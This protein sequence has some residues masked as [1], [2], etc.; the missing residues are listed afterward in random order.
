MKNKII[1][2]KFFDA[3]SP[4]SIQIADSTH[5]IPEIKII[6][7]EI[8][9]ESGISGQGY[10]LSFHYSPQA[11]IGTLKDLKNFVLNEYNVDETKKFLQDYKAETEY[12]GNLGLLKWAG[13][14][15]NVAMWDAYAKGINKSVWELLNGKYKP[16]PV[17]GSGGWLSY[18]LDELIEEVKS[19]VAR[20]FKAVKIKVGCKEI[21]KDIERLKK[22]REVVGDVVKIMIDANQGMTAD[23]AIKL[24]DGVNDLNIVWFE[25]PVENKNYE[26]YKKIKES[27][28][29]SLAMGEREYD[30]VALKELIKRKSIDMW[31]PDII[32]IGGVETWIESSRYANSFGIPVLPHYYKDYDVPLLCTIDNF[33]AAEFF[34]WIDGLIDNPLEIKYG[35]AY[36]RKAPGW[37][38][39]FT[40]NRLS[41]LNI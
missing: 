21:E 3:I 22:V 31:Q 7:T 18:T 1:D 34:D 15:L 9:T 40:R 26:G 17:Y 24:A 20:G 6:V 30:L 35:L 27:S 28:K 38:F 10:M 11:V 5:S 32:R 13:A 37:G 19:Y 4:V 41:E 8:T 36:P 12:F 2:I 23:N 39:S 29:I 14:L 25:E 16:I 33:V